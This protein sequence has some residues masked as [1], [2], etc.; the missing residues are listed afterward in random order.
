[1][2]LEL[3]KMWEGAVVTPPAPAECRTCNGEDR[4]M[5]YGPS[6]QMAIWGPCPHEVDEHAECEVKC[7]S[8]PECE[9][10]ALRA[11]VASKTALLTRTVEHFGGNKQFMEDLYGKKCKDYERGCA[12]CDTYRLIRDVRAALAEGRK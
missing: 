1:M 10:A 11:E 4:I 9:V 12:I 2:R 7:R 5:E 3:S 8:C 6:D